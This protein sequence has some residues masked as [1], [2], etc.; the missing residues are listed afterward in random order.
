MFECGSH[1]YLHII[2]S[3]LSDQT[4]KIFD[5]SYNYIIRKYIYDILPKICV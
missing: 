4:Q 1:I 5:I 3:T 2:K